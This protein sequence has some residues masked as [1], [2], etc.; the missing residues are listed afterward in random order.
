MNSATAPGYGLGGGRLTRGEARRPVLAPACGPGTMDAVTAVLAWLAAAG[1][2]AVVTFVAELGDK[3]QLLGAGLALR[4][5]R[6]V[7]LL[8][9]V[10]GLTL[11]QVLA[12][13]VG[14]LA[15]RTVPGPVVGVA[16]GVLLVLVGLWLWAEAGEGDEGDE[17]VEADAPP[18][19]AAARTPGGPPWSRRRL[20]RR[21]LSMR[22]RT[23]VLGV[24]GAFALSELGDKT[25]LTTVALAARQDPVATLVGATAGE[26][27][28]VLL[29]VEV[30]GRVDRVV[31]TL[32]LVRMSA[33]AFVVG[34]LV[35]V[36]LAL[37]R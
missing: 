19:E 8:G 18:R 26:L 6:R 27:L 35:L 17:Q 14:A 28:A 13:S 21:L 34:G 22:G 2:A 30:A 24:A 32:L 29:A 9:A 4:L 25:Q 12:V 7:V 5:R 31:P 36:A 23:A 37:L 3:S 1:A 11:L 33:A 20:G 16:S 10:L 15:S